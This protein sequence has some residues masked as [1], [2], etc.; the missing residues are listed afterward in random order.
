M[1]I[2]TSR[3]SA[4]GVRITKGPLGTVY[5]C[6]FCNRFNKIAKR[7][8][9]GSGRGHGLRTGGAAHSQVVAHMKTCEA[10]AEGRS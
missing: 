1:S 6:P 5:T 3:F 4:Q 8:G 7:L 2:Q 9:A 10:K